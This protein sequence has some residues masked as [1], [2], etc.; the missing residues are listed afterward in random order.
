MKKI[1]AP[2]PDNHPKIP[3]VVEDSDKVLKE[4][5]GFIK[6]LLSKEVQKPEVNVKVD[7]PAVNVESPA[8][9]VEAPKV[10]VEA[11]KVT[12]EAAPAD[13]AT[14]WK[15]TI[16]RDYRNGLIET[17]NAERIE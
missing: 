12:V 10:T 4:L 8:V 7:P 1:N 15:F 2:N 11:P 16:I 9:N 5:M 13:T 17:V 6:A 3:D 14:K